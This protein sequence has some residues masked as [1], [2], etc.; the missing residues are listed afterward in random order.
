MQ[1][2]IILKHKALLGYYEIFNMY[3]DNKDFCS[4]STIF[5]R[6][7]VRLKYFGLFALFDFHFCTTATD[8]TRSVKCNKN[9]IFV[10]EMNRNAA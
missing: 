3:A 4:L 9:L 6:V 5:A 7:S 2:T 1:E 8:W 10:S